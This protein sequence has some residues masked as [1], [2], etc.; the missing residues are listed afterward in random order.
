MAHFLSK[1]H[2]ITVQ[3]HQRKVV[4]TKKVATVSGTKVVEKN[5]KEI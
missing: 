3:A 1:H 2:A 5:G 4:S